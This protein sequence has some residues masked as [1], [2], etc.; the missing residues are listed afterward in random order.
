MDVML[1][2]FLQFCVNVVLDSSLFL[3]SF[4]FFVVMRVEGVCFFLIKVSF[5]NAI[6]LLF[7][8]GV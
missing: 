3:Q 6:F 2:F 7:C 4:L 1:P 8:W 5:F